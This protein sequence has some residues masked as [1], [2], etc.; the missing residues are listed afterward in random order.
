MKNQYKEFIYISYSSHCQTAPLYRPEKPA[1]FGGGPAHFER[2]FEIAA[3][4]QNMAQD[5]MLVAE[6]FFSQKCQKNNRENL[7][8]IYFLL[9]LLIIEEVAQINRFGAWRRSFALVHFQTAPRYLLEKLAEFGVTDW[10]TLLN[11]LSS[12][13]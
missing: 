1:Q 10:L 4:A 11:T 6:I 12:G 3:Y 5:I 9:K 2:I 8:R 7:H 13:L